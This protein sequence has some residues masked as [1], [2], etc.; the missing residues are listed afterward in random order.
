MAV[1]Y[2]LKTESTVNMDKREKRKENQRDYKRE[3]KKDNA[4]DTTK[5]KEMDNTNIIIGRNP[6]TEALRAGREIDKIL[7]GSGQE[8]SIKKIVGMARDKEIMIVNSEK[9]TLDRIA[10]GGA[11]QGV[12]A[13]VSPY[14]YKEVDDILALAEARGEDPFI[15]ILDGLEDPHNLGAIMRSCEG[16]GAHGVIIPKRR[17]VGLTETAAKA[18]A[19]AVEYVPVARVTNI[20]RT[21]DDLKEKGLWIAACDMGDTLYYEADLTGGIAIVIGSEGFGISRLV[22]EKCDF[23][24]SMPMMGKINSLNASNA[25][26]ILLYEVRR[27]RD[28][29]AKA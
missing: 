2:M 27:Q 20:A 24:V 28:I 3:Y 18:S 23:T 16:A 9:A 10:E 11:H 6:V 17:S 1:K 19:G 25:A 13:Y 26:A 7:V 22:S 5:E 8:G 4:S 29:K 14:E 15:V 12:I 21:I